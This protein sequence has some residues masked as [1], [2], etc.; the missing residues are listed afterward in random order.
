MGMARASV[1]PAENYRGRLRNYVG[2]EWIPS[3]A[4]ESQQV[5]NPAT[6]R[7][8]A[9]VPLGG[10][11]DLNQAV[12]A[13]QAA[14]WSW[15]QTPPQQRAQPL[16]ALKALMEKHREDIARQVT[17]EHG[18]TLEDARGSIQR[19]I[20]NVEVACGI[21]SLQ[22]GY[23]LEDGAARGIDEEV[24]RQPLG[25]FAA[26]CPFNFPAM[27]PFWF[28]PYA[29]ACGDTFI[30]KP[31]EQVPLTQS[32]IFEL[33]AQSGFPPGVLNLVNGGKVM[34]DAI[35]DHPGIR[36]VSFVGSTPVARHVYSR[37]A[38]NGKRVQAQGGAKNCL[39]IMPDADLDKT[40]P[41]ILGSAFGS[42]GQRCLAGSLA[43][44]VGDKNGRVTNALAEAASRMRVGNGLE[45]GV[46][47]GPVIS[48]Q[49]RDRI[50]ASIQRG[51]DEG[52]RLLVDGR[53]AARE[54]S[55]GY[56]VGPTLFS[57]FIVPPEIL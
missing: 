35:L 49:S 32:F 30:I 25:V 2:G 43:I 42:A 36:G 33:I 15:R 54:H 8:L 26:I 55:Q 19:A 16:Y 3:T 5:V 24:I 56:F 13:A 48:E 21:P 10:A 20:E 22:M 17:Q 52:A 14:F 41:N 12:S 46:D 11:E 9:E 28:L 50:L 37:A 39:V 38:A 40:I 47:V 23:G 31:S 4:A 6:E 45:P 18:K 57:I 34:V 51:V 7:A 44:V 27:V 53:Q 1:P 29:V